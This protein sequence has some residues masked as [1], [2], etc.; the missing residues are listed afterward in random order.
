MNDADKVPQVP[1]ML[2]NLS[3]RSVVMLDS[4][5]DI[6]ISH[7]LMGNPLSLLDRL[8]PGAQRHEVALDDMLG[9]VGIQPQRQRAW[10][11][12]CLEDILTTSHHATLHVHAN[13]LGQR[14]RLGQWRKVGGE[15]C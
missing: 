15:T 14:R 3:E 9:V 2:N 11:V 1:V 13:S 7:T 8:W 6:G 10:E 5:H 4:S 12:I